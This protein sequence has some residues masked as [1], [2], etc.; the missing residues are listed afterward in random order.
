MFPAKSSSKEFDEGEKKSRDALT[1]E[2]GMYA[3]TQNPLV[4]SNY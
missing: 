4:Q 2:S 1:D 3:H